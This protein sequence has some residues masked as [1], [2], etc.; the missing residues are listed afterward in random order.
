MNLKIRWLCL[1]GVLVSVSVISLIILERLENNSLIP[2]LQ[3]NWQ[4]ANIKTTKNISKGT[5]QNIS[6]S[7]DDSASIV[8]PNDGSDPHQMNG[9]SDPYPDRK[10]VV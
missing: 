7:D 2:I 3:S 10:S 4:A 8:S 5:D 1:V 6:I 9:F